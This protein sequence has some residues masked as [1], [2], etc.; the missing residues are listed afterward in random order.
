[1]KDHAM[2]ESLILAIIFCMITRAGTA[3]AIPCTSILWNAILAPAAM[4]GTRIVKAWTQVSLDPLKYQLHEPYN[5]IDI[6]RHP[7]FHNSLNLT[8]FE[9]YILITFKHAG[10]LAVL[11]FRFHVLL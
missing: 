10:F 1:M 11:S 2:L 6:L 9:R 3:A 7:Y 8:V 5:S 4:C